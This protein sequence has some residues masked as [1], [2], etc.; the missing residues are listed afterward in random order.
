MAGK[1]SARPLSNSRFD[2]FR[3]AMRANNKAV[4]I[5]MQQPNFGC[6]YRPGLDKKADG[7]DQ[8]RNVLRDLAICWIKGESTESVIWLKRKMEG[9][10]CQIITPHNS[11]LH[12]CPQ[13]FFLPT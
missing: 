4:T 2:W 10:T 8:D 13:L 7:Q 9:F 3:K 5:L 12:L 6:H 11:L 1:L